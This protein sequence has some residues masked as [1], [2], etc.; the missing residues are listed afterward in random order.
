[1]RKI[2]VTGPI[3]DIDGDEMTRV[4]WAK[5][6]DRLILPFLDVNLL[7]FDLSIQKRDE[8]GDRITFARL[9][10]DSVRPELAAAGLRLREAVEVPATEAHMGSTIL[11][12]AP[13]TS[14]R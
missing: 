7:Y 5:I 2:R 1:M 11:V 3:V 6:K 10:R 4:I 13:L 8:T 9:D 12:L 14:R